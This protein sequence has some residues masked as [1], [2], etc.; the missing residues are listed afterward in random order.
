MIDF[1]ELPKEN[2]YYKDDW[3]VIYLGDCQKLL[4]SLP[5][6]DLILTDPPYGINFV[7]QREFSKQKFGDIPIANDEL[8][9]DKWLEWFHPINELMFDRLKDDSVAYYYSGF[10]PYYYYYYYSMLKVGFT[11][12]AN[13]IWIKENF[14]MGYHFRRQYEQILVGFKGEPPTPEKPISDVIFCNKVPSKTIV[15]SCQK[16][17]DLNRRLILQYTK[18]GDLILDPFMGSGTTLVASK[19]LGR[20][21]IGIEISKEYCDIAIKRLAQ[22]VMVI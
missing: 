18:Q 17:E 21:T 4:P 20:K 19:N 9:G 7:P 6:V 14:G 11:I 22:S 5:K 1:N 13:L 15:H 12:K 2:L 16:P 10:N 3:C 8:Q